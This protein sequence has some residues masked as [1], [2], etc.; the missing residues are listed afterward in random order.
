MPYQYVVLRCVPRPDREEFLNVGVVLFNRQG[1]VWL[2]H[3]AGADQ[4]FGW[5]FPQG[6]IDAGE[7]AEAAARREL[8]EETGVVSV[9]AL[10][11]TPGW[12]AYDFPPGMPARPGHHW[13]GQKQRWFAFLFTGQDEEVAL[14]RH[15][16]IEF[17]AWRWAALDEAPERV[18][19]FKRQAYLRVVEAFRP[20]VR[21][22]TET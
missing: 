11:A 2:G 1:R 14:D 7:T 15:A 8:A 18:V 17:D 13:R 16:E 12:I 19:P 3:R 20:L 9:Q 21:R 5:Q 10:D 6:G 4:A 22:V